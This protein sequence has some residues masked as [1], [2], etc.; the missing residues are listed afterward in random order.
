ML[1]ILWIKKKLYKDTDKFYKRLR[2]HYGYFDYVQV[3]EPQARGAWH[4]H[5][6]LKFPK[7]IYIPNKRLGTIWGHGHTWVK[8]IKHVDNIGAYLTA[9][10]TDIPVD[11]KSISD[12]PAIV[13]K[14]GK[15]IL[16]GGRL[17]LYPSGINL[18]RKSKG[19]KLPED[20]YMPYHKA[21]KEYSLSDPV[22]SREY[23]L[24][25]DGFSNTIVYE[26]Y[27]KKRK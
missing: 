9:Y 3:I 5:I 27:N 4:S 2:Y 7:P 22:R 10:M 1:K 17:E 26:Q 13:N 14:N 16:K 12:N 11:N 19:I 6:L 18:Y 15:K 25:V 21:K 24:E 23:S 8:R 20:K